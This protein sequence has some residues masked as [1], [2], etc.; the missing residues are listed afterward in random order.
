M[1]LAGAAITAAQDPPDAAV[2]PSPPQSRASLIQQE[3][4]RKAATLVPEQQA[5]GEKILDRLE[6]NE[7]VQRVTGQAE[8]WRVKLGGL[9][10]YSGFAMGPEYFRRVLHEQG[11]F[12]ATLV[13]STHSFYKMETEFRMPS[14]AGDH[15]FFDI[16]AV[17]LGYPRVD[18]Y[19]PGPHSNIH[20]RSDYLL[21]NTSFGSRAGLRPLKR[22]RLGVA[23]QFL[24]V[25]VGPGREREFA[26]TDQLF[27]EQT[28]PGIQY[29]SNFLQ[30]GSFL[31]YDWRDDPGD[32]RRGGNYLAQF[33]TFDDVRRGHYSFDR[34]DLEADEYFGF[35]NRRRVI[36]LRAKIAATDPHAGNQVPFY[37]QPTLGGPDD[38]RG[39]RAFRF[40]DND[41][42]VLTGEYRWQIV[43]NLDMALFVDAGQVF[44][45]WQQIN[46][47]HLETDYGF[48][49]R[50]LQRN[51]VFLRIDTGFSREGFAIWFK[52]NNI[53]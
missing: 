6:H 36:A 4:H 52:F 53:F 30:G 45:K 35:F 11:T 17:R 24:A 47:R 29:Q 2:V 37:L 51:G 46:F 10:T 23:G 32:P 22:L 41:T 33:S 12:R 9:I 26:S 21:E 20:G 28:T 39:F 18:Y 3:R 15:A 25:N 31:Q 1:L 8:G 38:L 44:D 27:T 16:D 42:A 19:G 43:N 40:Y 5:Q 7:I 34:L 50:V 48:G 49:F 13:G 14:L